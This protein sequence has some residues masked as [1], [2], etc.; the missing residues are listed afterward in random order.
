[1]SVSSPT[2]LTISHFATHAT[3][4]F[5][6]TLA[7]V[8]GLLAQDVLRSISRNG[9]PITNLLVVDSLDGVAVASP[10]GV[11]PDPDSM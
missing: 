11:E 5:P 8:G 6:P 4:Y 9:W 7:I 1:M 2:E 10:W 3:D